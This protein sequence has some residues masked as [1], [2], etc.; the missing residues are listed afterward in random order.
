MANTNAVAESNN[1]NII[2]NII[3]THN[4]YLSGNGDCTL[5]LILFKPFLKKE[6]FR[7]CSLFLFLIIFVKIF[8]RINGLCH[9]Q[10]KHSLFSWFKLPEFFLKIQQK[11]PKNFPGRIRNLPNTAR[12]FP[13]PIRNFQNATFTLETRF[14]N[15]PSAPRNFPT[16]IRNFTNAI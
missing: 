7:F 15:I 9:N 8:I 12:R 1:L 6:I 4:Y 3:L 2:F 16:P 11:P 14:R 13:G 5:I 10:D